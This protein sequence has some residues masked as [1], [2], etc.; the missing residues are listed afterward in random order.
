MKFCDDVC[1]EGQLRPGICPHLESM[2]DCDLGYSPRFRVPR[3]Y[4][5]IQ[6]SNWGIVRPFKCRKEHKELK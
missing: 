5:D 6:R 1:I 4:Q 2:E 3:S